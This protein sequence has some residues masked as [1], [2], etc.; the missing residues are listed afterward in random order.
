MN[1]NITPIEFNFTYRHNRLKYVGPKNNQYVKDTDEYYEID[2]LDKPFYF[3][4]DNINKTLTL[5]EIINFPKGP[6]D[7][8]MSFRLWE[9][10]YTDIIL[11]GK[12]EIIHKE[13]LVRSVRYKKSSNSIN[14]SYLDVYVFDDEILETWGPDIYFKY[15]MKPSLVGR[16]DTMYKRVSEAL[17]DKKVYFRPNTEKAFKEDV[18]IHYDIF[19]RSD[20]INFENPEETWLV[21]SKIHKDKIGL[22]SNYKS[23]CALLAKWKFD[24]TIPYFTCGV[25]LFE[26][27]YFMPLMYKN[28]TIDG[29]DEVIL[30]RPID[31]SSM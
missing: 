6:M 25:S 14:L 21:F 22:A 9:E 5:K 26:D 11:P 16:L 31:F 12:I 15:A 20:V 1:T 4:V 24:S 29:L 18:E 28:I 2:T 13:T 19:N 23:A 27:Y 17:P 30:S 3:I 7:Q 10:S 8:N